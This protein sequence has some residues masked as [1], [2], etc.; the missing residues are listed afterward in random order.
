MFPQY[1]SVLQSAGFVNVEAHEE[2][3]P[4]GPWPKNKRL[5]E[6]GIYF[7]YQFLEAAVDGYS[8]ALFT[9]FGGWTEEE[10]QVLLAHVR[11]EIK[12]NKMHVYTHWYVSHRLSRMTSLSLSV[13][14]IQLTRKMQQ[15]LCN[16]TKGLTYMIQI[17]N[18][19]GEDAHPGTLKLHPKGANDKSFPKLGRRHYAIRRVVRRV[20]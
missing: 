17:Q 4:I 19:P 12:S 6:I 10:T 3:T 16:R 5:K 13:L 15:L 11:K 1:A 14:D 9:R 20:I 2:P 7:Q 18:K 8:L